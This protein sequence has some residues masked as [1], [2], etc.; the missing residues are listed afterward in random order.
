LTRVAVIGAG[1]AGLVAARELARAGLDVTVFERSDTVGGIW[2]YTPET[3]S[4]PLGLRGPRIHSS[5]YASLRTNLPRDLMAFT[6]YPFDSRGGGDD[7]WP[8]FP[9]HACVRAYLERFARDFGIVDRIRFDTDVAK[10]EP[11]GA[12]G[13]YIVT[14]GTTAGR[15]RF[16]AVAVC[17]GHYAEPRVP[18]LP[19]AAVFPGTQLHSHNYREPARYR[20]RR[21]AVLGA[22][23]SGIDLAREIASVA[24]CVYWCAESFAALSAGDRVKG[25]VHR[26]RAIAALL[27]D[28]RVSLADGT[29][30]E[31]VDDLV[32]CTGY[33][34][35]YPFLAPRWLE[36]EDNWV[37]GLYRD[38][39]HIELPTLAFIG[40]PFRVVPFP[41]FELQ[42]RWFARLLGGQ[43][44]L[45]DAA[46]M[47]AHT[48]AAV[49]DLVAA[50][51]AQRH[52]H[53]R[54]IDCYPYLDALAD[55]CG[56]GHPPAWQRA[57]ASAFLA[58]AQRFPGDA[59][60]RP[61]PHFGPTRV[62]PES[63]A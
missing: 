42:A 46:A 36:V 19:G 51:V 23:A 40:V 41:M 58:H 52:F 13:W 62:P 14:T 27:P 44:R 7:D 32:Y 49:A 33:R 39:L 47:R 24:A 56:A 43:F 12:G 57:L 22:S 26:V 31:P 35:R 9:P 34:Y 6:D 5:L 15:Q 4:D 16:D 59:R 38:I 20:G 45:P 18:T 53:Q 48:D 8:R 30:T 29:T 60:D 55:E 61:F 37:R 54:T 21:V 63:V 17:S 2:V 25:K 11:D 1:A 28:G 3:E 10:V 50:G